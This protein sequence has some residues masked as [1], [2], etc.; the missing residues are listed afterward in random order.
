MGSQSLCKP[1]ADSSLWMFTAAASVCCKKD[2]LAVDAVL[3]WKNCCFGWLEGLVKSETGVDK[4]MEYVLRVD[5]F[6]LLM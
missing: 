6:E 5:Y 1:V 3:L 2:F 4:R